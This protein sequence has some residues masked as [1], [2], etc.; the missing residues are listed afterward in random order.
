MAKTIFIIIVILLANSGYSQINLNSGEIDDI[1]EQAKGLIENFKAV[2]K[3][4]GDPTKTETAKNEVILNS[5]SGR[6]KLFEGPEIMIEDNLYP[7]IINKSSGKDIQDVSI[8]GY[9]NDFYLVLEENIDIISFSN[10]IVSPVINKEEILVNVY[11]KCKINTVKKDM[12]EEEPFKTVNRRAL[13]KTINE[14]ND[15]RSYII[16]ITFCEPYLSIFENHLEKEYSAF[17]ESIFPDHYEYK[18]KDRTEK[19]YSSHT[20]IIYFDKLLQLQSG[21]IIIE[22]NT[23]NYI[24]HDYPDSLSFNH[25]S[26]QSITLDKKTSEIHCIDD[27]K[28]TLID[29]KKVKVNYD[30][31][32]S[33]IIY[34]NKTQ[35]K[36]KGNVKTTLYSFPEENMILVHGGSFTMG[37]MV[38]K[39]QENI[40]HTVTLNDFYI[41]KYEVT[42]GEFKKFI[43]ETNYITDAERDSMSFIFN[44]KG[45]PEKIA[46]INW[47]YNVNG[48]LVKN[49]ENNLPVMHVTWNDAVAYANWAGKRLPTEAEW[50]YAAKGGAVSNY[51]LYSGSKKASNVA[52]YDKNSDNLAHK[53]G[54]KNN[55][56]LNIYDMTGN[57]AELCYDWYDVNYYGN[58]PERNPKGPDVG[59]F[60]VIRG[61]SWN[62]TDNDC[63]V[64]VRQRV[65]NGYRGANVGFRCVMDV[66]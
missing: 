56:E 62:V 27:N 33:A 21:N 15:R 43:E 46:N 57:V 40:E 20:E 47:K 18:F 38:N 36:F 37:S 14:D 45:E 42:V 10:I 58:S 22:N 52:W 13:V 35:T 30:N 51:Y 59:E 12:E 26:N 6:Q 24:I 19:I 7:N 49:S 65:K 54:Q 31:D 25:N 16:S 3:I 48:E 50:E 23:E 32:K 44:K 17:T 2:L 1:Q 53:V 8:E 34:E 64:F 41:D 11:Y 39:K 60:K 55:N 29:S 61:G 4:I 9:L 66:K 28:S 5:Y 63:K